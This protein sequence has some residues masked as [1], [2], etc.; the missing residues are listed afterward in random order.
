MMRDA[1][2][3]LGAIPALAGKI[4][5]DISNT[6]T[7]DYMGLTLGYSTSASR[8]SM[9]EAEIMPAIWSRSPV[10]TSV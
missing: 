9:P 8:P 5:V 2:A 10:S 7:V 1:S 3:A 6:L 4:V